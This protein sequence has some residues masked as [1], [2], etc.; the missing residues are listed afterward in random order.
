MNPI[1]PANKTSVF[2]LKGSV[3]TILV[4]HIKETDADSLYPQLEKKMNQA[5]SFF[6]SAPLLIDLSAVDEEQQAALDFKY[7]SHKLRSLG[8]VPVGVRGSAA[9]Q[10]E[11]VLLAGLGLL[12]DIKT[13]RTFDPPADPETLETVSV[14]EEKPPEPVAPEEEKLPAP[15][16]EKEEKPPEPSETVTS[17]AGKTAPTKIVALPVR[18]GQQVFA[19]EGD[20]IILSSVNAGAEV[21]AAGNIHIYGALRGRALAGIHGDT[22]ARIFSLQCNPELVAVAG[23]YVVNE[24]LDE[25]IIN[26]SVMVSLENGSLKFDVVGSFNPAS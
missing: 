24:L 7:L 13:E 21:L 22:T 15:V 8:V 11:R 6:K 2:E 26:Q 25:R 16:A 19:P 5:R 12:P 20:L 18:S 17:Q 10:K 9:G 3:I 1:S 4:L 14:K 23:E